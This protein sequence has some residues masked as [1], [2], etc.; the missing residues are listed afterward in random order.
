MKFEFKTYL[1]YAI[2]EAINFQVYI[3]AAGIG[4]IICFLTSHYSVVPFVVPLFVQILVRSNAKFRHRHQN[5]LV[6]L[7]AQTQDPV[8][9][10]DMQGKIVLSIGKTLDLFKKHAIGNINDFINEDAFDDIIRVAHS[11][12]PYAANTSVEAFSPR[13]LK[14]YEIKAKVTGMQYGGKEQKILV[15]LQDISQR[16]IYYLRLRDLLRYSDS[17]IVSLEELVE[18]G[19]EYEHLSSFLLREYEAVFITRA[20]Q[21]NNLEGYVFKQGSDRIIKSDVITINEQSPA[22]INISRKKK[23][24]ISDDISSY[25]SEEEFLQKNPLDPLVLDFIDNP[26]RN[27]ITY[28]EADIS[29][30]AFNFRSRITDYEIQFFEIVVN[31]YRSMVMLVDLKKELHKS[32]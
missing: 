1:K 22:P 5:A 12:D 2:K 15:W 20:D 7:P 6:E 4:A 28:N 13:S 30:I 10:M 11:Q 25:Q 23:Q 27:F 19:T 18:S 16:K 32:N 26:I 8:F 9:I 14:W 29:I 3:I 17:L 21:K 31:I 24:I